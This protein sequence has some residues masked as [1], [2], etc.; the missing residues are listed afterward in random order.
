M[1][2]SET[3]LE[4]FLASN[5]T[6]FIIP[7]Y[8][9][10]YDW[11]NVQ[12][13]QLLKDILT[14]GSR[15]EE[16]SHFIGS[17]VFV[18]DDVYS[19]TGITELVVIDGQQRLTTIT[20]IYIAL[21]RVA[22]LQG[23]ERLANKIQK[24]YLINEFSDEPEK[25]K[26]KP[27]DN[28]RMALAHTIDPVANM[29]VE[30][31]SRLIDNYTYF[32]TQI[33]KNNSETVLNGLSKLMFVEISLDRQNDNPQ[34]IFESLNSTGLEL[35]Q[36]DLIRNYILMGLNSSDQEKLYKTF[37]EP[38][39]KGCMNEET[40][41][42]KVSD[43]IRDYLTLKNKDIPNKGAVY[44]KFKQKYPEPNSEG[45]L[46]TLDELKVLTTVYT[47]LLNPSKETDPDVR[48]E[49][50]YI[51]RQEIA[52]AYP[53]LMKVYLDFSENILNKETFISVLTLVQSFTW[54]RL[55][56]G[57][58]TNALNK[59]FMTLYDRIDIENYLISLEDA[60]MQKTGGQRFPRNSEFLSLIKDKDIY[61]TKSRT[62]MYFFERVENFNNKE[63]VNI[64]DNPNIT[65]EHIFPQNPVK[66]WEDQ[67]SDGEYL[68]I[69][70]KY[71]NTIGNLTLSGNNG[72]L[73]N[74]T[75]A[76]KK[77]MN[78]EGKEQGY[79]YSRL[80]LN[81][82]L[83]EL[84]YWD[85]MQIVKRADIIANRCLEV[86]PCPEDRIG[87]EEQ[88]T[89]QSIFDIEEPRHRTLEYAVFLGEKIFVSKVSKLYSEIIGILFSMQPEAFIGT[90]LGSQ[91]NISTSKDTLRK[92]TKISDK[93][94]IES[95][96]SNNTKFE[97]L[98]F[99]LTYL[100]IEDELLI[101]YQV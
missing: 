94:F 77:A 51:N 91:V 34:R 30:T 60:L 17:I 68:R 90:D 18:H 22:V 79:S 97:R 95:N 25:L 40:N 10:N 20:L 66:D 7:V 69:K 14:V 58:P 62:R 31:F 39:E 4:K 59:I 2:A 36:A 100:D 21:Y 26:L 43:F 84:D 16:S 5:D 67:L 61:N 87:P 73:G 45:L 27:T 81:R 42:S 38:I 86:W 65:I 41:Q 88:E 33:S 71:L 8:Q 37:W 13:K 96:H 49:I 83:K 23:D 64:S 99:V 74:K 47:K 48:L 54:R 1:K 46:N 24:T 101:K 56:A 98:Q 55:V 57:L 6:N 19:S 29:P 28:N 52:V 75:F 3:R 70:D 92:P 11:T 78:D 82:H 85:E 50:A 9:R 93:Y 12:C 32:E 72:K 89:E 53:F 80:W 44:E 15:P 76:E 35:S 63:I